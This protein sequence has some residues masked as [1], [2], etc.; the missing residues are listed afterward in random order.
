MLAFANQSGAYRPSHYLNLI[1]LPMTIIATAVAGWLLIK[2][3][4]GLVPRLRRR[5][6]IRIARRRRLR[7][8]ATAEISARA[9]MD[10]LCPHG[11]QAEIVLFGSA[12]QVPE[13][14][15]DPAWTR[16][17]LD[18]TQLHDSA[19]VRR[20]WAPDIRQALE[21]MVAERI[22]EET[23]QQIEQQALADGASWP[24]A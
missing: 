13:E 8:A 11:W 19:T 20:I 16:V 18:W 10:E 5:L 7:A 21:A 15:P 1:A 24:D 23:L 17:Q 14:A 6:Q 22:A 12:D 2:M 3:L 9:M 4:E